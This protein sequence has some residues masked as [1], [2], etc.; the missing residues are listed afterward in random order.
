MARSW[1]FEPKTRSTWVPVH[2]ISPGF[3][4]PPGAPGLASFARPGSHHHCALTDRKHCIAPANRLQCL[5]RRLAHPVFRPRY[6]G[7][8]CPTRSG[9]RRARPERSRR[10]GVRAAVISAGCAREVRFRT[11]PGAVPNEES[12]EVRSVVG[13]PRFAV[14]QSWPAPVNTEIILMQMFI[15]GG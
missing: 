4:L 15:R 8:G 9:F 10:V 7:I 11:S 5:R 13:Q 1:E 6:H 2:L 12:L 3:A 14:V